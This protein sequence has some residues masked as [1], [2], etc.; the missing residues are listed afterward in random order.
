[1]G[2]IGVSGG[3]LFLLCTFL[4]HLYL[5]LY[6]CASDSKF[7]VF[8][9]TGARQACGQSVSS[10]QNLYLYRASCRGLSFLCHT[11]RALRILATP[12][13]STILI[14]DYTCP[15]L[16]PFLTNNSGFRRSKM[17]LYFLAS[18]DALEIITHLDSIAGVSL[19]MN[20][21]TVAATPANQ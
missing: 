17:I 10:G 4:F 2:Y 9:V 14:L 21:E 18:Q 3:L 15:T 20:S 5:Y 11:A 7:Y 19:S 16:L 1:M 6:L 8:K 13:F 12:P